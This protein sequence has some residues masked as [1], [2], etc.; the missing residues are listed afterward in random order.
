MVDVGTS[1][2]VVDVGRPGAGA[3][4]VESLEHAVALNANTA[5]M[6]TVV[7]RRVGLVNIAS[8]TPWNVAG[9]PAP[10]LAPRQRAAIEIFEFASCRL[11][12]HRQGDGRGSDRHEENAKRRAI[13][14]GDDE[15]LGER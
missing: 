12:E 13:P 6:A 2:I 5:A 11:G 1:P 15:V 8:V 14:S 9:E 7:A 10:S 3:R 4:D